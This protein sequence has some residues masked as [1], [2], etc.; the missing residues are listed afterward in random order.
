VSDFAETL[1][2]LKASGFFIT[3]ALERQL[4]QRHRSRSTKSKL[5]R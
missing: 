4:L 5:K 1:Q 3:D 2:R